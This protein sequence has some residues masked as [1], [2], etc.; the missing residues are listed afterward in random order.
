MNVAALRWMIEYSGIADR[1]VPESPIA[2]PES[3]ID[4]TGIR[5]KTAR[6]FLKRWLRRALRSRL[7]PIKRVA[8]MI[9]RHLDGIVGWVTWQISNGRLEGT[10]NRVRLLS[11][12][13]YG[14]HSANALI[15]LVYLC[16]GGLQLARAI[17]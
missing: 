12:R 13:S 17:A 15:M 5:K 16:C 4:F 3:V 2:I 6:Q 7:E 1:F 14:L 9:R 8:R 10:N 11:H